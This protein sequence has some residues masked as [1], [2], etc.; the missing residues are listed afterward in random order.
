MKNYIVFV[1]NIDEQRW[2]KYSENT[3]NIYSRFQ[4]VVGTQLDITAYDKYVFYHNKSEKSKRSAIGCAES[5]MSM[6]KYIY[7]NKINNAIVIEDD[8]LIDFSRLDELDD[9]KGF[10]YIG[11]RFQSPILTKDRL[12]QK[13]FNKEIFLTQ[14]L[15]IIIPQEFI[16]TAGHGYYFENFN[17]AKDILDD[18][19]SQKRQRAIDVEFKRIQKKRPNLINQFIYPAISTLHLPDAENGFTYHKGSCW[20][21]NDNN[22]NY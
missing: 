13:E 16:I 9:I 17:V 21:L 4:G 3:D 10:C 7:E 6:M 2:K 14:K 15:N 5:H 11:G 19:Q 12:F 8:A 22:Y 20:K 1:I 18:I